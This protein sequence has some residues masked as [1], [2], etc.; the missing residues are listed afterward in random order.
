[1]GVSEENKRA[2]YAAVVDY[3]NGLVQM[4][5][6]VAG[7]YLAANG[8][9]ASGFFQGSVHSLPWYALPSLGASLT[10]V[11]WLLEIRTYNLLSN[12]GNRGAHLEKHLGIDE[13]HGFFSLMGN[14]PIGARLLVLRATLPSNRFFKYVISHS[15]GLGMLYTIVAV[16]WVSVLVTHK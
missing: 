14:Q 1:V 9:L 5:F 3:H 12:L 10:V 8:F 16:F 2:V 15:F 11:C 13:S 6:T 7:L 4:R